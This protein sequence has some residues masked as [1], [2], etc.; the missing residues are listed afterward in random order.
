ML[1]TYTIPAT[2]GFW[3]NKASAT[4]V[5]QNGSPINNGLLRITAGTFNMGTVGTNVM[6]AG[7]G[8]AFTIEGGTTN[9][10]GR[11]TS[12]NTYIAYTQSG[13]TVNICVAGG[14]AT[15]PSFG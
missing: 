11:L 14:C 9:I 5:G 12:A 13:G 2:G 6:G 10:A 1:A 4:V 3:L 8:A 7:I 15:S